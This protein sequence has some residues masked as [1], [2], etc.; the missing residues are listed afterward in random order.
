MADSNSGNAQGSQ[1]TSSQ[2]QTLNQLEGRNG[3]QK[4]VNPADLAALTEA[5][6]DQTNIK[7][8]EIQGTSSQRKRKELQEQR[9]GPRQQPRR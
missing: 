4:T 7:T 9:R 2:Q 6:C 1:T 8:M 3:A 5:L